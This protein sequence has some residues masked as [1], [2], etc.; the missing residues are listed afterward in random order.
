MDMIRT[1]GAMR[2]TLELSLLRETEDGSRFLDPKASELA[3]KL[4]QQQSREMLLMNAASM[5]PPPPPA[6]KARGGK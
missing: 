2:K 3:L 5:P 6:G 4:M 1:L